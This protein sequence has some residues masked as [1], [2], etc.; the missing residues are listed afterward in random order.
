[1][2]TETWTMP[3]WMEPYR[4]ILEGAIVCHASVETMMHR[5]A[6]EPYLARTNAFV[7]DDAV[8]TV[9]RVHLLVKLHE[10][11]MLK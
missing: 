3:E 5:L 10:A 4:Q 1:M 7:Y 2:A 9:A 8:S 6:S 11:G